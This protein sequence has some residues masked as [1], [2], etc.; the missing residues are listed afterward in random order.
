MLSSKEVKRNNLGYIKSNIIF[1]KLNIDSAASQIE[2]FNRVFD[3]NKTLDDWLYKHN[4]NPESD[5][6][7]MYA[8]THSG[9]IIGIVAYMPSIYSINDEKLLLVQAC[10]AAIDK[11]YRRMGVFSDIVKFAENDLKKKQVDGTF[12]FPNKY[13]TPAYVKMNYSIVANI[14]NGI[15]INNFARVLTYRFKKYKYLYPIFYI[16]NILKIVNS[17]RFIETIFFNKVTVRRDSNSSFVNDMDHKL[18]RNFFD[19]RKTINHDFLSWKIDNNKN[20]FFYY[21]AFNEAKIISYFVIRKTVIRSD[22]TACEIVLWD[23]IGKTHIARVALK[24][25]MLELKKEFDIITTILPNKQYNKKMFRSIGFHKIFGSKK[26]PIV[27][28]NF[29]SNKNKSLNLDDWDF[30]LI[31]Y[32]TIAG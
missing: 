11:E 9:K 16:T 32:D 3:T 12:G 19:M 15:F 25:L 22:F 24:K 23:F 29:H 30:K 7:Y 6:F 2:L 21:T 10:D 5:D 1:S 26:Q 4:E 20:N 14:Q 27:Y 8:A 17:V 28:R 13:S 18:N 31:E